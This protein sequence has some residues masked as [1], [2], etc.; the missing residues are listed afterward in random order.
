MEHFKA[1]IISI[2]DEVL[3]GYTVNTNA[4]FISQQLLSIG[5]PVQWVTTISDRH[6]EI[7][8]ALQNA[9]KRADVVLVTG[10]LGPTPDDLTKK[11]ICDFFKVEMRKDK[12]TLENVLQFL[13][14]RGIKPS[15]LNQAQAL[16]PDCDLVI[17]NSVGTA[18]CLVFERDKRHY[19]FMPGVPGEMKRMVSDHIL[20]YLKHRLLLTPIHTVLLRTTGIP[21]SKLYEN[22]KPVLNAFP[23]IQTAFLPRYIGVDLRFKLISDDPKKIA[24]LRKLEQQVR[25]AANKYIISDRPV[26]LQEILGNLLSEKKHSLA[27]AESFTGGLIA[28][29]ITNIPGSSAYFKAGL[30]TYSN[31]S[32]RH[33]LGVTEQTLKQFGAVSRETALEMVRGVQTRLETDCA[34]S[35]TGIAGP[36]GA[37]DTKPVGLCYIAARFKAKEIVKEFHFGPER[38]INKKRGAVAGLELLRRLILEHSH[39]RNN[40]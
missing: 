12:P 31:E 39:V 37:T 35:T 11:A 16:I 5:L 30:V 36:G 38:L 40:S 18:P 3:A 29:L 4:T 24:R 2:G 8:Q 21:E 6:D 23:D 9:S 26:E 25:S 17:P 19:F 20:D 32:K 1:E 14:A 28:D 10:G 27:V 34:I 33:L 15:A 22:L 7:L 13:K